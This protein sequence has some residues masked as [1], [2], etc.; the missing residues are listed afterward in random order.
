MIT[1]NH[2]LHYPLPPLPITLTP[3][4]T[5]THYPHYPLPVPVP[6]PITHYPYHHHYPITQV[7]HPPPM[8]A[9]VS[10]ATAPGRRAVP[11]V[12][13]RLHLE[14]HKYPN[15]PPAALIHC[16][17]VFTVLKNGQFRRIN[18]AGLTVFLKW[19]RITLIK[20]WFY[21]F[22]WSIKYLTALAHGQ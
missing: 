1:R 3:L 12:F 15:R 17:T 8:P 2:Y 14:S 22:C 6:V 21:W 9:T 4:P 13:T 11:D 18:T 7:P 5:I 20:Q 16:F 10:T 19:S